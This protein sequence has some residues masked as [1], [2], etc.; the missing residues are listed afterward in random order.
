MHLAHRR[1]VA[2]LVLAA[3][4]A[5]SALALG[6]SGAS[7]DPGDV[8]L[9]ES[10][11]SGQLPAGW[12]PVEGDWRVEGGRLVVTAGAIDHLTFG[13]HLED[14][15]LEATVRFERVANAARWTALALDIPEEGSTPWWQAAMRSRSTAAN[16]I[17]LA[18][19]T[20][21]NGWDVP[22]TAAA[23]S[24]AGVGK[25]V[26]VAIEVQG[27]SATW[28]FDG[29]LVLRG[30]I[31]R[32]EDGVLGLVADNATVSFDDIVVTELEPADL[33]QDRGELPVTIAHRGYSSILPE[34]T[35]LSSVGAMNS[36]AEYFEIDV[37]TTA[38]GVPI[39]LHDQTVDRTTNG[40]G[41]VAT[42]SS[43]YLDTLDAG[44]WKDAPFVAEPLPTFSEVLELMTTNPGTLM[45]EIKGPETRAEV[46][47]MI[48][49]I[50]AAGMT[51]RV[52]IES[53]D[54][55]AVGY[56]RDYAPEIPRGVLRGAVDADPVAV[57]R[58][59]G[60]TS[61]NPSAGG[62]TAAVVDRLHQAGIAVMPYTVNSASAWKSLTEMGVDGIVTDRPGAFIGWKE[63]QSTMLTPPQ[64]EPAPA[65]TVAL[66]GVADGAQVE[67]GDRVVVAA[68]S[69]DAD[70]VT[71]TRD[72]Q[73]ISAGDVLDAADLS[74]G[75]H[76]LAVTAKGEG[77]QATDEVLFTVTV[78]ADGL[79]ARI[80][81]LRLQNGAQQ[82]ALSAVDAH[83][84]ERLTAVVSR[85]AAEPARTVLL[86][87]IGHLAGG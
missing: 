41:D 56:A 76:A 31:A 63:A 28:Y 49:L 44:S 51:R 77:G 21:A 25:D 47:R 57:A 8:V 27:T 66:V 9:R 67:R 17:E 19:R 65:P 1:P 30:Q 53:F 26:R 36:G 38:D 70:T 7:A 61:Y 50:R 71:Y 62:L 73:E 78:S 68:R 75:E 20:A 37:H 81:S 24:D 86:E 11:D 48:D 54:L 72:G 45:L 85:H 39:V 74:L 79:R 2:G 80:A 13:P 40:S 55:A 29:Q 69:S 60:A 18:H 22:Y 15:R 87:E 6:Q 42:L 83:D 59:V 23:P 5:I 12:R 84:W 32:T 58:S 3:L 35:L 4:A 64:P 33:V 14:Y 10:F 46:Q 82:Q 34:N 52:V 16:G 43:S